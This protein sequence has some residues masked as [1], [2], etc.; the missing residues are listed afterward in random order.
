MKDY[1]NKTTNYNLNMFNPLNRNPLKSA[2][3]ISYAN[4]YEV[5]NKIN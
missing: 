3:D 2:F 1:L 5:D 4:N